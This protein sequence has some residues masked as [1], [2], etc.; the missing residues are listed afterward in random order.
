[1]CD[2]PFLG[3]RSRRWPLPPGCCFPFRPS[4]HVRLHAMEGRRIASA[5][6]VSGD[7]R[8]LEVFLLQ[9]NAG[10][11]PLEVFHPSSDTGSLPHF[12]SRPPHSYH[13]LIDLIGPPRCY[14]TSPTAQSCG[15]LL[16]GWL[17]DATT[18]TKTKTPGSA[19][20]QSFGSGVLI[21]SV[22]ETQRRIQKTK[23]KQKTRE[24]LG[25]TS[26][27][28]GVGWEGGGSGGWRFQPGMAPLCTS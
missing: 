12:F 22:E 19:T 11:I 7:F 18:T 21:E 15:S 20:A 27:R 8:A 1:M 17:P 14:N 28:K 23:T 13:R 26:N 2:C 9:R 4:P 16:H 25:G 24:R 6:A 10:K 3:V 5:C